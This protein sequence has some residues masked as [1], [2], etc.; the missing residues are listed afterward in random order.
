MDYIPLRMGATGSQVRQVQRMLGHLGYPVGKVDGKFGVR[1]LRAVIAFQSANELPVDGI[2]AANTWMALERRSGG[3]PE[4][5]EVQTEPLVMEEDRVSPRL[6][7]RPLPLIPPMLSE[8]LPASPPMPPRS[9]MVVERSQA[10]ERESPVQ[11]MPLIDWRPLAL[12][13]VCAVPPPEEGLGTA[14]ATVFLP[15]A[16]PPMPVSGKPWTKVVET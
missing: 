8:T 15:E 5:E 2:V 13:S 3:C 12:L 16:P 11:T 1:T 6:E 7:V 9:D 4:P 10:E 14:P